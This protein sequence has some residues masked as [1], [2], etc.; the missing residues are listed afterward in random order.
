MILG[1]F[2]LAFMWHNQYTID[3]TAQEIATIISNSQ[4]YSCPENNV[5]QTIAQNKSQIL[6]KRNLTFIHTITGNTHRLTSEQSYKTNPLVRINISCGTSTEVQ[7]QSVHFLK[8]FTASLPNLRTGEKIIL[9]PDSVVLTSTK[10][11]SI[12]SI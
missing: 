9:I 1:I 6:H 10:T 2:E 12:P 5:L 3:Q 8:I 4:R 11:Y 7:I